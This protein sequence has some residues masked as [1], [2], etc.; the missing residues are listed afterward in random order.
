MIGHC[1]NEGVTFANVATL[2]EGLPKKVRS[3][4]GVERWEALTAAYASTPRPH[5][6]PT[7]DLFSDTFTGIPSLRLANGL[8]AISAPVWF[9]RF[10]NEKASPIGAAHASDIAFTF[11]KSNGTPFPVDW[12]PEAKAVSDRMRDSFVAFART[13]SPQT[14]ALPRWPRHD[15]AGLHY[16]RFD[17]KPSVDSDFIG[18]ARRSVWK[19][20]PVSA[21]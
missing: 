10:D 13:G 11:G 14:A 6:D 16:L 1:E 5:R 17:V 21:V 9:Y 8:V 18:A 4:V 2:I 7:I 3:L 15:P 19:P 20:V 12:T